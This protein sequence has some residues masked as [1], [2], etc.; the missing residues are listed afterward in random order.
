MKLFITGNTRSCKLGPDI[1]KIKPQAKHMGLTLT[2]DHKL[3]LET[4]DKRADDLKSITF[5][6]RSLGSR[7]VPVVPLSL[8]HI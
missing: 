4:Y 3:E 2:S 7:S 8:I 5:A 1:V 6:A